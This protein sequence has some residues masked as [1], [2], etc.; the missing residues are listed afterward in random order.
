MDVLNTQKRTASWL[1]RWALTFALPLVLAACGSDAAPEDV[2]TVGPTFTGN[3]WLAGPGGHEEEQWQYDGIDRPLISITRENG[4]CTFDNGLVQVVD[5]HNEQD[6]AWHALSSPRPA[7]HVDES[8]FPPYAFECD[9]SPYNDHRQVKDYD[10]YILTYS[11]INDA[12]FYGNLTHDMYVKYLG[13]P[14]L[15]DKIRLRVHYGARNREFAFWDGAYANFSDAVPFFYST[16]FLD[17]VA[18]E[19]GHGVLNRISQLNG[20]DQSLSTDARTLHEVFGDISGLMAKYEFTG[21]TD[22]W[23]H[24]EWLYY[25]ARYLNQIETEYGA[26]ASYLDYDD[27]DNYYQ[28]IGMM[29]YPFYL[30]T[31][32]W[33]IETVYKVYVDAARTCWQATT[34][35]PQAAQCIYTSAGKLGVS[36]SDVVT[37]FKAVKIKLFDEGVLSHFTFEKNHL[38]I[39]VSDTSISTGQVNAWHWDFGDGV[40]A[41][42]QNPVHTYT[43]AGTYTVTLTVQ[44]STGDSDAFTRTLKV[45]APE[46]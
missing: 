43:Q 15:N 17:T 36:Q 1:Y 46:P 16:M 37:A 14:P 21:H 23:I 3:A 34:T 29:T 25:Y 30:L 6:E 24:G 8:A 12:M 5:M 13:E 42:A 45:L 31:S 10:D 27:A 26:I 38:S 11:I 44:D 41:S 22:N 40:S 9:E 7:N 33:G 35:L 4:V 28:R 32:D 18:H 39:N 19:I 2:S 20:F